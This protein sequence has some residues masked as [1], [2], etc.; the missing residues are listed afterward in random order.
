MSSPPGILKGP[1]NT[2]K[3]SMRSPSK[4]KFNPGG[5]M[6]VI[7]TSQFR[8]RL[9]IED[10]KIDHL[11]RFANGINSE[12]DYLSPSELK[13]LTDNET[14]APAYLTKNVIYYKGQKHD[15]LNAGED[16]FNRKLY[17]DM[18]LSLELE[19]FDRGSSYDGT[20][21][22]GS[23][24]GKTD[25]GARNESTS[26]K[27]VDFFGNNGVTF[28]SDPAPLFTNRLG[29][30]SVTAVAAPSD[31]NSN[32]FI[33]VKDIP[34]FCSDTILSSEAVSDDEDPVDEYIDSI[35]A[36]P[37]KDFDLS[38]FAS[39]FINNSKVSQYYMS[40]QEM[41][42]R[43]ESSIYNT[44]TVSSILNEPYIQANMLQTNLANNYSFDSLR[45][46]PIPVGR[47]RSLPN[48][49]KV[50]ISNTIELPIEIA[51]FFLSD[52]VAIY[53]LVGYNTNEDG[54]MLMNSPIWQLLTTSVLD[55]IQTAPAG[56][57]VLCRLEH[58]TTST[59]ILANLF[60]PETGAEL[61]P[62]YDAYFMLESDEVSAVG[63]QF[64]VYETVAEGLWT[65]GGQF[66]YEDPVN[67]FERDYFGYY[68][69]LSD[70][71]YW[72]MLTPN[73]VEWYEE[74]GKE[75]ESLQLFLYDPTFDPVPWLGAAIDLKEDIMKYDLLNSV[76]TTGPGYEVGSGL[77]APPGAEPQP[78]A[79]MP[80]GS[81]GM[82]MGVILSNPVFIKS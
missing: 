74:E 30:Y 40:L 41:V 70:G 34:G 6:R 67:Y 28:E 65:T 36:T 33:N 69:K 2:K 46:S 11:M 82:L 14:Y 47:I 26:Q 63:A 81:S 44:Q 42:Q 23:A 1:K 50:A 24:L 22:L 58:E 56:S 10:T 59:N 49:V 15:P 25:T 76:D 61:I 79:T 57:Q 21:R 77:L 3:G 73:L 52:I 35:I 9:T 4:S 66:Y 68:N 12:I 16:M 39:P 29:S 78:T 48:I 20:M 64:G 62:I 19:S 60:A 7:T 13:E 54:E 37:Y 72:T 80:Y 18:D 45:S 8:N 53:A 5:G 27:I 31:E 38:S 71:S 75:Y 32:G 43:A 51:N 17:L 55:E